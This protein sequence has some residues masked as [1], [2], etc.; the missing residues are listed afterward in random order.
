M[1]TL[2]QVGTQRTVNSAANMWPPSSTVWVWVLEVSELD[3]D[4]D[5]DDDD[6]LDSTTL[7]TLSLFLS[8]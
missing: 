7:S 6:D 3:D 5:D 4:D 8:F 1:A 2:T